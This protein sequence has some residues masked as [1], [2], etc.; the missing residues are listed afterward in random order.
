M[1]ILLLQYTHLFTIYHIE[2]LSEQNV[3][4][5]LAYSQLVMVSI[6]WQFRVGAMRTPTQ[7]DTHIDE[8]ETMDLN[9]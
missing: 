7:I 6:S 8:F 9:E 5:K 4:T 1:C 3:N 2:E